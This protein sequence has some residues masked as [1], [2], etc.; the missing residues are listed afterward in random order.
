MNMRKSVSLGI[1]ILLAGGTLWAQQYLITTVAGG[2]PPLT[3]VPAVGTA[4]PVS[5]YGIAVDGH[6][7]VYF[8]G[9]DFWTGGSNWVFKVDSAGVLTRVAGSP[10]GKAGYSGDGGPATSA[11]LNNPAGVAVDAAGNLYIADSYSARI[12]KV[13]VDGTI[14]TVAGNGT[15]G[16][17]GDGGPATG[18]QLNNPAGVAVDA[19]GNLY[20][21]DTS[22]FC[23]RK[24]TVGGT[25]TTVAELRQGNLPLRPYSVAVDAAGGLYV[26]VT[27]VAEDIWPVDEV[28]KVA[29]GLITRVAESSPGY[30]GDGSRTRSAHGGV[31]LDTAGNL[32]IADSRDSVI[33]KV[34]PNG[35]IT[36]VAGNG[37]LGYSGDGG[38]ATSA[39]ITD[40]YDVAVDAAGN[41]YIAD[42]S[43][44]AVRKV[45][46]DGIITTVAGNGTWG[47]WQYLGDGGP[48]ANA[49]L[50]GPQGV[51]VDAPGSICIADTSN[52]VVRKVAANGVITTMAGDGTSG[53]AG[54]GGPAT[55][56]RFDGPEGLATDGTGNL[57][58]ADRFN[59]KIRKVAADGIVTTVAN[60]I[61]DGVAVDAAGNLYI[62][63][64]LNSMIQKVAA[65]GSVT[66]V[67]GG[68]GAGYSGDGGP[69]A[70]AQLNGPENLA[71][72]TAGNL[73]IADSG[74]HVI[75]K[76]APNGIITTVAGNG[77]SGYSG[78]G[79]LAAGAQLSDPVG[80]AVDA[81]GNLY[82]ADDYSDVIRKVAANGIITTVAGNGTGGY[83]G[84][85]G[86]ATSARLN[87][88]H[89]L[90]VDA[91]GN[92]YIADTANNVIR[93]LVPQESSALLR[94]IKTHSG[95]FAPG[96]TGATYSAVVSNAAGAVATNAPVTMTEIVPTGLTLVSMSG[97]GWGCSGN[98]CTRSDA[99]VPGASYPLVAVTVNVAADPPSQVTNQV[100]VS[101][102]GSPATSASDMTNIIPPLAAPVLS[103]P[104][105]GA[106]G[107]VVTPVLAWNPSDGARSYDV[108][109][110]ASAPPRLVANTADTSYATGALSA[111]SSYYWQVV[112]R[113]AAGT[114]ASAT[115]SFTTGAPAAGLRFVPVAPCRVADTRGA[116]SPFGGPS[117]PS[118]TERSF[119]IPQSACGIPATAQAYSLN[120]T[121]VPRGPVGFLTVW[122]TGQTQPF[123]STLNAWDGIVA[124]NAAIVPA[125]DAGAVSVF[126]TDTRPISSWT[127][128]AT[129]IRPA[130][131]VRPHST[132]RLRAGRPTRA[133]PWAHSAGPRCP[134]PWFGTSPFP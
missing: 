5:T 60:I 105:N 95:S 97:A 54:D 47:N 93:L 72:D 73:Y 21:A 84:D 42:S 90:A 44:H 29:E 33:R 52:N 129:S 7:N 56:A 30:S 68:I 71:V 31:A 43:N 128:T 91:A 69:A 78:D 36:T 10:E 55:S 41:L 106:S 6:R 66:T 131:H 58:V 74:N 82:I 75:R 127:S 98:T 18:A 49:R 132:P 109:F 1:G 86:S 61:P 9:S 126:V 88:P 17:S 8:S 117:L 121:A 15:S 100:S 89:G 104:A 92:V 64:P 26:A 70:S 24:V 14:T 85:G 112:A 19:A 39:E 63:V 103:S 27:S 20:I 134:P 116:A 37:T 114:A 94:V 28:L 133:A 123:V 59:Y 25:I 51:V 101:G 2:G 111:G 12:R 35:I 130:A 122:P 50:G 62:S 48:A 125:G 120:V 113:N 119:A 46:V 76:V 13:A 102:G 16:N 11:Q 34:A 96:Q 110:G 124:A 57:Y 45:A 38:A 99:L 4:L 108:Y 67:A 32:Y 53:Y 77:I 115:W 80:V 23:I 40:P 118:R 79:G 87:E 22:N 81:A 83:S 107:I 65:D 3:G